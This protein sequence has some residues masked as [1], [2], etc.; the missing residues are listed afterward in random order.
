MVKYKDAYSKFKFFKPISNELEPDPEAVL[1]NFESGIFKTVVNGS[2][3]IFNLD[4]K[5]TEDCT[6][7][8][9]IYDKKLWSNLSVTTPDS[10]KLNKNEFYLNPEIDKNIVKDLKEQGF[11]SKTNKKTLA[12]DKE[13]ESYSLN[14]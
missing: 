10:V 6:E 3:M 7:V 2:E 4:I 14:I 5:Y 1:E 8:N 9:L 13:T 11:I 12:G